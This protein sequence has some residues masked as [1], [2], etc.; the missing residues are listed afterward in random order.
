MKRICTLILAAGLVFGAATGASAIDFKAKGQW[1]MGFSAGNNSLTNTTRENNTKSKGDTGDGFVAQQRVR[2]QLDAVASEALSGTVYFEIGTQ[3]WGQSATGGSL[4]ADGN[5]QVK[6]KNAYIDWAIPQTDA[7]VR[8]GIQ[9]LA[10]PNTVAGGSAILDT[11]V[12]A[13]VGSYKFNENVSMTAFWARPF[14][15]NFDGDDARYHGTNHVNYLDNMDLFGVTAPLTFDGV[16]LTP[17]V[18]Y[19]MLGKNTLT[20]YDAGKN[21][22]NQ[23]ANNNDGNPPMTLLPAP[24]GSSITGSDFVRLGGT[25]KSYGSMF[26]A[27]LPLAVTMFD[28]LNIELDI[29][30]GYV[31]G[32]GRYDVQ[33]GQSNEWVRGSSQRQGW[34]AKA[35]V[36]YKM[37]WATP[38]LFGWY[39]SGDDSSVKNGSER[40]PS[41]VPTGNFTSYMGDGNMGWLRQDYGVDYAG[42]WGIGA[43]L[44]DMSFLEDLKHTF[45]LAY[46]GGTNSTSMVKY[47]KTAYS[48][49]DGLGANTV[50][51]LTT[52]DG[53]LEFNLVNSYKIYQNLEMNLELDYMVNC[54]DNSTWKKAQTP[55]SFSKQDMYQAKVVFAYSF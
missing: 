25:S 48:W 45:R 3:T 16:N 33:K 9:G 51:Y 11:D 17:W 42:T 12:A 21:E 8:M 38:G 18:M 7:K 44:K 6:V 24:M 50:P 36:E 26:W 54:M 47:M 27:G 55:S 32:M 41:L 53:L 23:V 46:W 19:G 4:G 1:L 40:M 43:Q 10:L 31:E 30:Y 22:Y 52:N 20:N 39:A 28:P 35:L 13:V 37:D 34:L 15:D 2:L 14:N 29:N 5:N 49:S